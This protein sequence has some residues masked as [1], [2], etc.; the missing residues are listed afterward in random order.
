MSIKRPREDEE[1]DK[2]QEPAVVQTPPA[3]KKAK[4]PDAPK[5]VS[6]HM[7]AEERAKKRKEQQENEE[8]ERK[9]EEEIHTNEELDKAKGIMDKVFSLSTPLTEKQT[10]RVKTKFGGLLRMAEDGYVCEEWGAP[11]HQLYMIAL[12]H[13]LA[14]FTEED[15]ETRDGLYCEDSDDDEEEEEEDF[16][17]DSI[18]GGLEEAEEEDV[19]LLGE[20]QEQEQEA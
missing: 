14:P 10:D 5:K 17:G 8:K 7:S 4:A 20:T 1:E 2:E 11:S 6:F 13:V 16:T 18:Q 3:K 15:P 9:R 12:F 19:E